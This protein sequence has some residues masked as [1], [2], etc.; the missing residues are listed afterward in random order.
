MKRKAP[1]DFG[2]GS[3]ETID[4]ILFIGLAEIISIVI[5]T[6]IMI[7][8]ME[9]ERMINDKRELYIHAIRAL[10]MAIEEKDP[11]TKMHSHNVASF[12]ASIASELG[13]DEERVERIYIAGLLHDIGK[14]GVPETIINKPD[15]LTDEEFDIIK[16]HPGNGIRII[17]NIG[18]S[19]D[20]ENAVCQHHER[21]DGSG[22]QIGLRNEE[23]PVFA[24]IL[25][26]ADTIDAMSSARA[27]RSRQPISRIIEELDRE[28][29]RQFD[30]EIVTV[31]RKLLLDGTFQKRSMA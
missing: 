20:I 14:I 16:L 18:F 19:H 24:R 28:S 31:A 15:R 5:L 29:G 2:K 12:S 27:Y 25:A 13:F 11:Y 8:T 21:W 10:V 30:P 26:V 4:G 7:G 22:Y 23:L 17:A 6:A 1:W 9:R 3:M